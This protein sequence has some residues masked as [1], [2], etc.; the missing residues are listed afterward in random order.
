MDKVDL[1][2]LS[3]LATP[4]CI[5]VA[6]TLGVAE[7]MARGVTKI[8]ELARAAD[9]DADSL[10]RVLRHL[11]DKG[12]FEEPADGEF[13]LNE[14]A[15]VLVE[16]GPLRGNLHL[17]GWG[18]RI[19]G[20]WSG[21]LAAVRTGRPSYEKVFGLPYWEDL[22]AN[23]GLSA[24]Y[25]A[26]MKDGGRSVPDPAALVDDDWENVHHVVDVGGGTGAL[27]AETLRAHP[28]VRGTLVDLPRTVARSD[29]VFTSAG[30]ADRVAVSGQSFFDPL[31]AGADVYLLT[32]LLL[33]WPD[34]PATTLLARCAE[35]AAP[36]GR[37]VVDGG[38]SPGH[39]PARGGLMVMILTG[40]RTRNL[41]QFGALA[42]KAGLRVAA[43]GNAPSG[44]F[45][46]ECR[47]A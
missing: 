47:P 42:A 29:E 22:D 36:H 25:D 4:W 23:P 3:D 8:D 6:V 41:D 44:R 9:C 12:V 13:A 2:T 40:G 33:D 18:G 37:V 5:R 11:V 39:T 30:V 31:P 26:Q 19:A 27:L 46:V 10:A 38:V 21:L 1:W 20:A 45:I 15:R 24:S 28:H 34:E 16:P 7:H 17:D 35:A 43:S 32:R 14:A